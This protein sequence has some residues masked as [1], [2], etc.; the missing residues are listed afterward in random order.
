MTNKWN[1]RPAEPYRPI[2]AKVQLHLAQKVG[3]RIQMPLTG[4]GGGWVDFFRWVSPV[5]NEA[6]EAVRR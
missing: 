4:F 1:P 3:Q 6:R 2:A 5:W